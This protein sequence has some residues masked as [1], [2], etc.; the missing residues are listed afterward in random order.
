MAAYAVVCFILQIKDRH[1]GNILIDEAGHIVHIDF[2]FIFDSS[3]GG[4]IGFE[5]SPFKLSQ[6]MIDIMGGRPDAETFKW[7]IEQGVKAF[8]AVRK[9]T[10]AIITLVAM[11]MDTELPCFKPATLEHLYL[12][13]VPDKTER[14]AAKH[15]SFKMVDAFSNLSAYTTYLYDLFQNLTQGIDY[16]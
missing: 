12:R 6:E 2:G 7:F 5:T 13:L 16:A 4:D 14:E 1:N 8:L 10:D 11:M 15:M 3:P 9:Y